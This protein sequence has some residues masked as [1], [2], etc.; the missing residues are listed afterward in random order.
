MKNKFRF[1]TEIDI[2]ISDI[3]YGG[4]L[5]NDRYLSLFQEG[6]LRYLNQFGYTEL[7]IGDETG[8]IMSKAHIEFKAE[9]FWGDRMKIYVRVSKIKAIKFVI[10]YLFVNSKE[11]NKIVA[12]GYTEMVGFDYQNRK[13][14]RLPS[15]FIKD[16]QEFERN[17]EIG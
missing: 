1:F 13:V 16:I 9:V 5:G 12:E 14:T 6:R 15:M 17:L 8:L 4:H 2:Q 11:E 3:N 7:S 10:E